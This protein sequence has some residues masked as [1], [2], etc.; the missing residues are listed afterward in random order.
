MRRLCRDRTDDTG[1]ISL[2]E[3]KAGYIVHPVAYLID[4][5]TSLD[6]TTLQFQV[7]YHFHLDLRYHLGS[8]AVVAAQ[9]RSRIDSIKL[10]PMQTRCQSMGDLS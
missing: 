8:A 5:P 7:I 6:I 4:N 10:R 9:A 2:I 3:Q 1:V